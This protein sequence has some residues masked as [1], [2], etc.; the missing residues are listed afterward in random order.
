MPVLKL[1]TVIRAPIERVFDLSRSIDLHAVSMTHHGEKAIGGTTSGLMGLDQSVTWRAQH[2]GIWLELTS[3]MT[4]FE[5]PRHFRDSHVKGI[6]KRFDHDHT[7]TLCDDTI[8]MTDVFDYT[9][10]LRILGKMADRLYLV[11]YMRRL[12]E[13]RNAIIKTV[14][15]SEQWQRFVPHRYHIALNLC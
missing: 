6:F 2:F 10:P 5:R 7:F 4:L 14:A 13:E 11:Q 3:R 15:E 9:S 12:L 1:T 8:Q